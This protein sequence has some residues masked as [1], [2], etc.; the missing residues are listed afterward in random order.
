MRRIRLHEYVRVGEEITLAAMGMIGDDRGHINVAEL[1][2]DSALYTAPTNMSLM[3]SRLGARE[4]KT[5]IAERA[6]DD[7]DLWKQV[8]PKNWNELN[9]LADAFKRELKDRVFLHIPTADAEYYQ[10][11][12]LLSVE[13]K[14][15]FPKL[16]QELKAAGNAYA[17]GL[18]T[19][20]VF[21]CMRALEHSLAALAVDVGLRWE[22][23]QWNNIIEQIEA[24][25]RDLNRTLPMGAAKDARINF[26]SQAAKEFMYFKDGW[27]NYVAHN[28]VNYT[29]PDALEVIEHVQ[30][31]TER[32]AP[33]LKEPT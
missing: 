31:F 4:A 24:K 14:A 30:A 7:E 20:S 28:R 13:A 27:R 17:C 11:N 12:K 23:E 6:P 3:C 21:H 25:V 10:S 19:A 26:L 33:S 1:D 29:L 16:A 32:L 18:A 8:K 9:L 15:A 22:K 2:P 5:L